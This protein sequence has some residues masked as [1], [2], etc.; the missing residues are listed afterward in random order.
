MW[1]YEEYG[2]VSVNDWGSGGG[3]GGRR[4]KAI[5]SIGNI[6]VHWWE[7]MTKYK[8]KPCVAQI[9]FVLYWSK[10]NTLCSQAKPQRDWEEKEG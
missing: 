8:V 10:I 7:K 3:G 9:L 1:E 6:S 2:D 5:I 4:E